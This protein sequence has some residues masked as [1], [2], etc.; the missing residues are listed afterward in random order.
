MCTTVYHRHQKTLLQC[1]VATVITVETDDVTA[2]GQTEELH[3][4]NFI[5]IKAEVF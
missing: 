4:I 2:R 5:H 1:L 3:A